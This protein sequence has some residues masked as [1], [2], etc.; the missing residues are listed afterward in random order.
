MVLPIY[1]YIYGRDRGEMV[2]GLLGHSAGHPVKTS[3][4]DCATHTLYGT[5]NYLDLCMIYVYGSLWRYCLLHTL[6]EKPRGESQAKIV[7]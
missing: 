5:H 7:Y 1:I 4:L 6:R 3:P 2:K